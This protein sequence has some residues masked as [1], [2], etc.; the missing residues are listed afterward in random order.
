M[1]KQIRIGVFETNSSSTHSLV[2]C[3]KEQYEKWEKGELVYIRDFYPIPKDERPK[4]N[5]V[6]V[7]D[8]ELFKDKGVDHYDILSFEEWGEDYEQDTYEYTSESGDELVVRAY[9][10][11]NG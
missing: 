4:S 6:L 7:E 5:F 9:Y 1:K 2:I 3:S 8:I 10:G 11:Y